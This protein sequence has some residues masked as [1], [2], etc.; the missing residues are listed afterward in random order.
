MMSTRGAMLILAAALRSHALALS[1]VQ[2]A[3][4]GRADVRCR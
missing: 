3:G 1:V 4:T 2:N